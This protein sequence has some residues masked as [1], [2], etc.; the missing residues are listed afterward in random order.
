MIKRILI[1][2]YIFTA[3][4]FAAGQASKTG[5]LSGF[6]Y[7]EA[8]G[9]GLIGANVFFREIK[10]G[11]STNLSG[12]YV[13]PRIPP[14][15]YVLVVNYIGYKSLTQDV[16]IQAGEKK[17]FDLKLKPAAVEMEEVVVVAESLS[18][19][20]QL[21]RKPISKVQLNRRQINQIP[22]VAEADLL[23]SLQTLPGI[24][25]ISDFSSA[26]YVRGGTPDQNLY[27]LDGTDV[28]NPEHAFG[29]FSTFNTDA[30]KHV[31]LSKGGFGAEYGGRLSS[32]LDVTNLDGNRE[33][34]QGHS[35]VSLLSAKTT[36]QMPLGEKGAISGSIR[37]T[38]LDQ[39]LAKAIDDIPNYYFYDGNVKAFFDLN[40][41][42]N[43]TV[44]AYGG[45]DFLDLVFNPNSEEATGFKYDW[46]N[47]TASVRWTHVFTPL[48]FGNFWVTG[49]RFSSDFKFGEDIPIDERNDIT[50]IT[51]KGN[52]DFQYSRAF[53]AKFGFE[54]KNLDVV[55]KQTFPGGLVDVD[56]SGRQFVGYG[57]FSLSPTV[58]WDFTG[59]VRFTRFSSERTFNNVAPR[60][61]MKYRLTDKMSLKAAAG[62]YYQYLHKIPRAFVADIWTSANQFQDPSSSEHFIAGFQMEVAE[63]YQLEI[64]GFRK[65]YESIYRFDQTFLTELTANEFVGD[66]PV[67]TET[68]SLFDQGDGSSTGFE[69]LFRK[70]V[71]ALTGWLGYS[72]S[73][74]RFT[75][76][77]VN[78]GG[79]FAPRHDRTQTVNFV[80]NL[81]VKNGLRA[82]KGL[83]S[84]RHKGNWQIGANFVYSTGQP[85]TLPGSA[86]FVNSLPDQDF[87][88]LKLH[89]TEI[90]SYRLPAYARLDVSIT[91]QKRYSGWSMSPYLQIFNAGNRK[92]VWF[93]D[94]TRS[95]QDNQVVQHVK[96][97]KMFPILPTLGIGFKF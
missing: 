26:L 27:L 6:V 88:D 80:A 4:G 48:L 71:G 47:K 94:Y 41:N 20:E 23:R 39:T 3:A 1:L 15:K 2:L 62:Q 24:L 22:Q 87:I 64:E 21:Y 38:Y 19:S 18:V 81:D 44:S 55:Y 93:I 84:R 10:R 16:V 86:Y 9:E 83:P 17:V 8:S 31:E 35:Q 57:Q 32:V 79:E 5:S 82:L 50:D 95:V 33:T 59:G 11:A 56:K 46:G 14:G 36:L 58:R 96:T 75:F 29:I 52:L 70:D 43:L 25:P 51:F 30:I 91:Y 13:I 68:E 42:N 7:D 89:P 34:F 53:S 76:A 63:D 74:T 85:I 37:R 61:S 92:N 54:Q 45:R 69:L 40:G 66:D 90:N 67:Y 49:S 97:T 65:N 28:Y 77:E 72:Y 73:R 78:D 12:Y 60:F